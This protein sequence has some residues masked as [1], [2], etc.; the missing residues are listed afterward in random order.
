[1][2]ILSTAGGNDELQLKM[3]V[4]GFVLSIAISILL[5]VVYPAA[6]TTGY[7]IE[8]I[9]EE[10]EALETYTGESMVNQSPFVLTHVYTPYVAG[11]EYK[12]TADGW[13]YGDELV[14]GENNP[15]YVPSTASS[16]QIGLTKGIHLEP[17]AKSDVPL[18]QSDYKAA[19]STKTLKWY[20]TAADGQL[21]T[22]GGIA[23]FFGA[24]VYETSTQT[25]P[26]W[27]FSGYRYEFDPMLRLNTTDGADL[28]A[29]SDAT[30]SIVWYDL[31]GQEGISGG[32]VLYNNITNGIVANYT[33]TEI[34]SSYQASSATA[35]GYSLDF[36]GT[37]VHMF[38]QFD[39]DVK[40][41]GQDLESAW[42]EGRWT[43]AFT[44]ASA[45]AYLDITNSN[46]FAGS[47]GNIID[48]YG[49]LMTLNLPSISTEWNLVL[50]AI[51][52]GPMA[53]AVLLFLS[54]FGIAGVG[55]GIVGMVLT[56]VSFI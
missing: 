11:D 52:I 56:G 1:M 21:N 4:W 55:A 15:Y 45:D 7:T 5:P 16:N 49:K 50:W 48:T 40:V 25:L 35:T 31:D 23:Q 20:Y 46:S 13:L 17:T 42:T 19:V 33:A 10:R 28:K 22:L 14:D 38:I 34:I 53:M 51:C 30:L 54:R 9:Y 37:N 39:P 18:F 26:A 8:D 47:V 36:N 41:N 27:N 43:V 24:D 32:L 6:P 29:V 3:F 12:T 2:G 44:C